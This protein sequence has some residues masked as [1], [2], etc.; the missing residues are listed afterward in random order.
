MLDH[1]DAVE[2][3]HD[4]HPLDQVIVTLAITEDVFLRSCNWARWQLRISLP[5]DASGN[6]HGGAGP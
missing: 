6:A 5:D 3:Q 4:R 2:R 1:A